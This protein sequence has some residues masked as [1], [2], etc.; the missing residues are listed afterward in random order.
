MSEEPPVASEICMLFVHTW[1]FL[2]LLFL[3]QDQNIARSMPDDTADHKTKEQRHKILWCE[4]I[5]LHLWNIGR[6]T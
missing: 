1:V 5:L 6:L 2:E 3:Y 4:V